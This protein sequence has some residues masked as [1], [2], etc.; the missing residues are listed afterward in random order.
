MRYNKVIVLGIEP[1]FVGQHDLSSVI[2][3]QLKFFSHHE[4]VF[5]STHM[6]SIHEVNSLGESFYNHCFYGM[7]RVWDFWNY[8][9]FEFCW[10]FPFS[11]WNMYK[12]WFP[13]EK[14][15]PNWLRNIILGLSDHFSSKKRHVTEYPRLGG[16]LRFTLQWI[17]Y[18][19][20]G[21][22]HNCL[23]KFTSCISVLW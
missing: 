1:W 16:H 4:S 3:W 14:A 10:F 21:L 12:T 13:I 11:T 8:E 20:K 6:I 18:D 5:G 9:F 19:E 7:L 15:C 2:K 22:P 23:G 17:I